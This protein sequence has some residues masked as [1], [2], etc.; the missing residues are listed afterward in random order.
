MNL[1]DSVVGSSGS[2]QYTGERY[3]PLIFGLDDSRSI[4][5]TERYEFAALFCHGKR[6]LEIGCGAG[7][8]AEILAREARYVVAFDNS[9]EAIE[10]CREWYPIPNLCFYVDDI[11][12]LQG[13]YRNFEVIVAYE[14]LE[15]IEDGRKLMEFVR[16]TLWVDGMAFISTPA[17]GPHAHSPFHKKEYTLEEFEELLSSYFPKY[18]I[19]N[20][21]PGTFSFRSTIGGQLH[22]LIGVV[23]NGL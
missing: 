22:T 5:H 11:C 12:N 17:P 16:D 10:Y 14:I 15:H 7:Y 20:H 1:L 6:V 2:L 18:V 21:R 13:W 23:W 4:F 8:G 19:L 9:E 3:M